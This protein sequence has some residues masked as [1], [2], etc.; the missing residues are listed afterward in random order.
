MLNNIL[1]NYPWPNECPR[2]D[3]SM[4]GWV[5]WEVKFGL[6]QLIRGFN[7]PLILEVGTWCGMSAEFMLQQ[8]EN[9]SLIT[10]DTFEGS[11]EHSENAKW[12]QILDSGLYEQAVRNLWLFKDRLAILKMT[13]IEG[14][15]TVE[16][17]GVK[18]D[19][20]YIDASHKYQDVKQDIE[21]ALDCFPGSVIC[22][23]DYEW[24]DVQLAVNQVVGQKAFKFV[25]DKAFWRIER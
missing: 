13:S 8:N 25:V 9:A 12:R 17:Y 10:V 2:R 19:I 18:P 16:A 24:R 14:M 3:Y 5:S 7:A 15:L 4:H 6:S 20:V 22:G 23:D 1:E 11:K 21:T